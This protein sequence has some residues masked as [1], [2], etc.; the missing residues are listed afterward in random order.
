MVF[1]KKKKICIILEASLKLLRGSSFCPF[2]LLSILLSVSFF[3]LNS[4]QENL[5]DL[6][7][8]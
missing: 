1:K 2:L 5:L 7:L 8:F 4:V 6:G 3:I